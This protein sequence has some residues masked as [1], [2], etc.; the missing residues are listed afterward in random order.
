MDVDQLRPAMNISLLKTLDRTLGRV[1]VRVLPSRQQRPWSQAPQRLLVI[2]PGGIGDAALLVAAIKQLQEAYPCAVIE[3]LAEG[4]NAGVFSLC[5]QVAHVWRYESLRDW[6][7]LLRARFDCI[8]DTEQWHALSAVATRFLHASMVI[9]F[10]TNIRQ[11][12]YTHTVSYSHDD[13]ETESFLHLLAPLGVKT[14]EADRSPFLSPPNRARAI[15]SDL[16]APLAG[17]PFI[18]IFPGASV[19]ERRWGTARFAALARVF[20]KRGLAV[21]VVG[22]NEDVADGAAIAGRFPG[23]NLASQTSLAET[24]AIIERSEL[25]VS[26]DSGILHIG[27]GLGIP[28]VSLFGPGIAAKWAPRGSQHLVLNHHYPCSPCTKFGY[29]KRCRRNAE[30]LK[31]ITTDEVIQAALLLLQR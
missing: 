9:G 25:L 23:L 5:P 16:L 11:R 10:S 31:A 2:R 21:V 14:N 26:G 3:V 20:A 19:P 24:A 29:T 1:M 27:V 18:V 8:I 12:L 22:G 13:Y 15:A 30:C 17:A 7:A 6:L 4:R 28:T